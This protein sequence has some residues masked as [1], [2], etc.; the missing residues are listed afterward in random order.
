MINHKYILSTYNF[1][2]NLSQRLKVL[3]N[4][5][6]FTDARERYFSNSA[7]IYKE[8]SLYPFDNLLYNAT[9]YILYTSHSVFPKL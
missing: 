5:Y 3:H 6:K 9:K 2:D 4:F 1:V 7:Y 8:H